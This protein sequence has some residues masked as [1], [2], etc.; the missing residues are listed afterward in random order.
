MLTKLNVRLDVLFQPIIGR[1]TIHNGQAYAGFLDAIEKK[2]R[3]RDNFPDIGDREFAAVQKASAAFKLSKEY[4]VYWAY[5]YLIATKNMSKAKALKK[6]HKWL[7]PLA[8]K[9]V[10]K[11][12]VHKERAK[13]VFKVAGKVGVAG[14]IAA[15]AIGGLFGVAGAAVAGIAILKLVKHRKEIG[16]TFGALLK[17]AR[18]TDDINDLPERDKAFIE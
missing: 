10:V 17:G 9:D 14:S 3:T 2:D 8:Y 7:P 6:D 1:Y 12:N 5:L 18:K 4:A 11:Y 15:L 13:K 16:K